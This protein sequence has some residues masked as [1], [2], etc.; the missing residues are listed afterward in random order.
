M[1][2][3]RRRSGGT[4]WYQF[5]F[6]G[7]QYRE[8][9]KTTNK[10]VAR[11]AGHKR[12]Q[13]LVDSYHGIVRRQAPLLFSVASDEWLQ[14]KKATLAPKSYGV[15]TNSLKHLRPYFGQRLLTD[16]DPASIA[17]YIGQRRTAGA[18]DKSIKL[19]IGTLRG[20]LMH[21]HLWAVLKDRGRGLLPKLED[22]DDIGRALSSTEEAALLESCL[23]SRSRGLYTAVVLV[24]NTGLRDGE[25][26]ALR[27][28]QIDLEARTI[29]VGKSK[30]SAGTGRVIPLNDRVTLAIRTWANRFPKRDRD[31]FVFPAE[32]YGRPGETTAKPGTHALNPK[33]P[34][35][36][37]KTG[38]RGARKSAGV[39]CRFHDLR[40]TFCTRLLESG[41]VSFP[42][43]ASLMG[44]SPSTT[45]KMA[46]RY[47]HIGIETHRVAVGVL[48]AQIPNPK[49]LADQGQKQGH[50][51]QRPD[52]LRAVSR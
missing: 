40:H 4:W 37:W 6:G 3:F 39:V 26:R 21:H 25:A 12:R 46:K 50:G 48:D 23:G 30:T 33:K 29:T 45:T 11:D 2:L 52:I 18:A 42:I 9:A 14:L 20:I 5:E 15:E 41:K 47:G 38:W 19:E 16:I 27:W 34:I 7:R 13:A 31:H 10:N 35:R 44:W 49:E 8:S 51:P 36:S 24:L 28:N 17:R 22:R 32:L 1:R 43:V